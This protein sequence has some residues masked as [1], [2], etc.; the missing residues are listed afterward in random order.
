MALL[1]DETEAAAA[2]AVAVLVAVAVVTPAAPAAA[3]SEQRQKQ[4]RLSRRL[5]PWRALERRRAGAPVPRTQPP[6]AR[7]PP[8]EM[9][10]PSLGALR[11]AAWFALAGSG[12]Q[13]GGAEAPWQVPPKVINVMMLSLPRILRAI[14]ICIA[15]VTRITRIFYE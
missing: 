5:S 4:Q 11:W 15:N 6:R 3:G 9:R 14:R 8:R 12:A 7:A 1:D 2:V 13:A 10:G